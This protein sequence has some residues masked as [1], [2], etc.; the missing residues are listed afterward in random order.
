M[1]EKELLDIVDEHDNIIGKDTKE[2]KY[3]NNLISR[4]VILFVLDGKNNLI[5]TK[6]ASHKKTYPNLYDVSA[7]GNV[8][9][10][11]HPDKAAQRELF[12]EL[13]VNCGL[14]FVGKLFLEFLDR[15]NQLRFYSYIYLGRHHGEI[16][17]NKELSELKK[18]PFE[19]VEKLVLE[20][21]QEFTPG[22][23][24]DFR[25]VKEF[26]GSPNSS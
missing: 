17:L 26:L 19:K 14:Q 25:L 11:E 12:E 20:N 3:K 4:N 5:I 16:K 7:C 18:I 9:S 24:K 22:F 2:N 6:R 23:I 10:G 1:D 21:Q 13:G 8:R 15:G